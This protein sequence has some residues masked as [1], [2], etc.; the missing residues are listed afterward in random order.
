MLT[1]DDYL[2]PGSLAEAFGMMAS[3]RGRYRIIA[4]ATDTLPWAREGRA[5]D[6][7]IP[8]LIDVTKIPELRE[9]SVNDSRVRLGAATPI[10][11]FL[12]DSV[13]AGALPAMPRSA[14]WFADDQIRAQ[15]TIGGNIVNASPAADATPCLI[16]HEAEV[17]LAK[18][19]DGKVMRRRMKLDQF[20]TGPN[21]TALTDGEL[22]LAIECDALPGYGGSF[23]KVGYRRSLVISLVCLATV[24]KLDDQGRKIKAARLAIAGIAPKPIRLR[25]AEEFLCNGPISAERLEQAADMP[26][27]LVASRT[28]KDYRRDVVRGFMLR[29]LINAARRAGADITTL[30]PEL[31][32]A[33]A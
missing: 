7:H 29:G 8:A 22:L 4:G 21:R 11:R 33:Y 30:S 28:R 16:A 10:Q 3:N 23:E 27:S 25:Q 13:L 12:D 1:C 17:E 5:G 14:V 32:A 31:E 20:V 9:I 18:S 6:V 26:A 24:L 2:T 19:A 15:A